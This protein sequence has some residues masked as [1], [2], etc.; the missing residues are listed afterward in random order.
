LEN[1]LRFTR[2]ALDVIR[3][4]VGP[5]KILGIRISGEEGIRGGIELE[6]TLEIVRQ[7][8]AKGQID[9]ISVSFGNSSNMYLQMAPMGMRLG[10]LAHL[11][12][13]VRKVVPGVP[14]LAV[15]RITTPAIA[16]QII[17]EGQADLV[18]MARQLIADPEFARKA[19]EDRAAEIRPCVGTN[20]CQSRQWG[21]LHVSCVHNPASGRERELGT[22]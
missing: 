14:V 22:E 1:R 12:G 17:A 6:D 10:Y 2:Q 21:H 7:L 5:Q 20:F 19:S 4:A 15:G 13:A 9:Y 11:A 3:E 18:G 8:T 16:E